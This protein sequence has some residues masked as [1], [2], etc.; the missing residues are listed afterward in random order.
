MNV[1]GK[2]SRLRFRISLRVFLAI[3]VLSGSF[4]GWIGAKWLDRAKRSGAISRIYHRHGSIGFEEGRG[5]GGKPQWWGSLRLSDVDPTWRVF[6]VELGT[7]AVP[8]KDDD[9]PS[10]LH[11]P[12]V[13]HVSLYGRG[14]SNAGLTYLAQLPQLELLSLHNT[15]ITV[16]ALAENQKLQALKDLS[17]YD[18]TDSAVENIGNLTRLRRVLIVFSPRF[19]D[20][21]LKHLATVKTLEDLAILGAS[22]DGSGFH[23]LLSLPNLRELNLWRTQVNN[24]AIPYLEKMTTLQRLDLGETLIDETGINR[25]SRALPSCEIRHQRAD[26]VTEVD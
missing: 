4:A 24:G 12:E 23:H 21:G 25:L 17:L 14:F 3:T 13:R 8:G 9:L 5:L 20:A 19:T 26:G 11:I 16:G 22:V 6:T 18:T 7:T 15:S 2:I 1:I 10:L